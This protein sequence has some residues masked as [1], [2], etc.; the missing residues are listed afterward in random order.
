MF[1]NDNLIVFFFVDDICY[2]FRDSDQAIADRFRDNLASRFKIRDLGELRWFLGIRVVRDRSQRRLWLC[3][4]SYIETIATRFNLI[5]D[6]IA[7]ATPIRIK[8]LI[9]NKDIADQATTYLYQRK[10]GSVLYLAIISRSNIA[11]TAIKLSS[12]LSNPSLDYITAANRCIQYL[13]SIRHLVIMFDGLN[14]TEEKAFRA[15]TDASFADDQQD[16]KST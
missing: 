11:L 5:C 2:M 6:R 1:L 7:P 8:H 15:Y 13:Y 16:R 10:I 3:Q 12:F 9:A 4:D 14:N